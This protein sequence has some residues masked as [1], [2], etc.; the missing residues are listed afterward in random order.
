MKKTS[1]GHQSSSGTVTVSVSNSRGYAIVRHKFFYHNKQM[2]QGR[3]IKQ[4]N[5]KNRSNVG[6]IPSPFP[7]PL[8][9][10]FSFF[11]SLFFII[12]GTS[13]STNC[14][15]PIWISYIFLSKNI[16]FWKE[17]SFNLLL[18]FLLIF[19]VLPSSVKIFQFSH[20]HLPFFCLIL[21]VLLSTT[22]P[23]TP[24]IWFADPSLCLHQAK[25]LP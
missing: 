6:C 18:Y 4:R 19:H 5:W 23:Q 14:S 24:L 13:P 15:T 16:L 21:L 11:L 22:Q 17:K 20:Q 7:L 1:G 9:F 8:I 2:S 12:F 25:H 10:T 3:M